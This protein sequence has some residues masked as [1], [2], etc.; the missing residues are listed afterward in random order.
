[1]NYG[2]KIIELASQFAGLTEVRQNAAWDDLATK[3]VDERAKKLRAILEAAGHEDGWAYCMSFCR[4]IWL[5]A[6][7]GEKQEPQ[8]KKLLTPSVMTSWGNVQGGC[9][10]AKTPKVG[11]IFFMRKN[12]TWTGHAGIVAEVLGGGKM[13]TVEGN[14]SPQTGSVEADRNGDGVYFRERSSTVQGD[15]VHGLYL[16]GFLHPF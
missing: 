7:K 13:R 3:G 10:A 11:S 2:Q 4:A 1:M 12:K 16:V 6:Y 14:T 8:I 9:L 5:A 15:V